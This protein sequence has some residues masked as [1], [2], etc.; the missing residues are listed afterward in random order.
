[1][2]VAEALVEGLGVLGGEE[3]GAGREAPRG[4]G[5]PTSACRFRADRAAGPADPDVI[6]PERRAGGVQVGPQ[7]R[8]QAAGALGELQAALLLGEGHG[9]AVRDDDELHGGSR[10]PGIAACVAA[11]PVRIRVRAGW[12]GVALAHPTQSGSPRAPVR[13]G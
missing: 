3:H 5:G 1:M 9:Q 6:R 8:G 2:L 7:A 4:S 11:H 12:V 13:Q 10:G